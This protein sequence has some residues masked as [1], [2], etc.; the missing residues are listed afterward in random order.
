MNKQELRN[1]VKQIRKNIDISGKSLLA[2]NKTRCHEFYQNANNIMIY[3]PLKYEI[4]LLNLLDLPSFFFCGSLITS[5]KLF[6]T[7]SSLSSYFLNIFLTI[8]L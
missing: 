1:K 3:Y 4:N 6:T 2:V 8:K 5:S 7:L